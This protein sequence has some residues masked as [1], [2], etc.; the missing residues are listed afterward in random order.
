MV[1]VQDGC[2]VS[3]NN[4]RETHYLCAECCLTNDKLIL[5]NY[6]TPTETLNY[7]WNQPWHSFK[8][9]RR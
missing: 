8:S 9:S 6:K 3:H 4:D 5:S 7:V 1:V 2:Y